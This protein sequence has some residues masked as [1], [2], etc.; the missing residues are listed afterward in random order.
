MKEKCI[1][2]HLASVNS[3]NTWAKEHIK[4]LNPT[5]V[6]RITASEQ[7]AGR[8]RLKR[9]WISPKDQ[10][11][12]LTYFFSFPKLFEKTVHLTQ[13]FS[14]ILT[15]LLQ[16]YGL[17]P[18]IKWPNDLLVNQKKIG[19]ILCETIDMGSFLGVILGLGLNINMP[20]DMLDKIDQPATSFFN[21]LNKTFTLD[22]IIE[23]LDTLFLNDL[24]RFKEEGFGPFHDTYLSFLEQK[25]YPIQLKQNG[26]NMIG[27]FHSL[28]PDGRLNILLPSGEI[29]SIS[30][31]DID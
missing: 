3:T 18:S 27:E 10:N 30:T 2:I 16:E 24:N 7:T 4:D 15:T 19:G 14:V 9:E 21:E 20:P 28:N 17:S 6:T 29:R 22:P 1:P 25:N 13:F 23:T 12:Y 5:Q 31:L 8:G 26:Q 11:I